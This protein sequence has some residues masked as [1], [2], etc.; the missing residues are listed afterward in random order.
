MY[1]YIESGVSHVYLKNGYNVETI[2]GEEFI[3]VDDLNGLHRI[4]GA[5]IASQ[6]RPLSHEEFKFLRIELN[7]SQRLLANLFGVSEQTIARYEKGQS[8]IPRTTDAALRSL[9]MESCDQHNP[10]SFFLNLLTDSA[11]EHAA[12]DILLEE[13]ENKWMV[14]SDYT[15]VYG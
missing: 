5:S 9:Y 6:T 10:V 11:A 15:K 1:H 14:A 4:L 8:D 2:D 7:L 13:I 12:Q 3:S